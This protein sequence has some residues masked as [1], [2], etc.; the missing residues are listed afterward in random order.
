MIRVTTKKMF[1]NINGY[2]VDDVEQINML[3]MDHEDKKNAPQTS[4]SDCACGEC[5]PGRGM[6]P[7]FLAS[8]LSDLLESVDQTPA[9]PKDPPPVY[10]GPP[11]PPKST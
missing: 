2:S 7:G 11:R 4:G 3:I 6:P 1:I 9:T 10:Y 5:P 8:M